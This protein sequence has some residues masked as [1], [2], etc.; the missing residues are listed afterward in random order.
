MELA[1]IDSME[2]ADAICQIVIALIKEEIGAGLS[3]QIASSVPEDLGKGWRTSSLQIARKEF[4]GAVTPEEQEK[5]R[6]IHRKEFSGE[7]TEE[8]HERV[9][10]I[11]KEDFG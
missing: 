7:V 10:K 9:R 4:S 3:D 1:E 2:R 11:M 8:E 5:I 6:R